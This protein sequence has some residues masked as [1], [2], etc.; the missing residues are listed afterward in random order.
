MEV[1]SLFLI[2]GTFVGFLAGLLGIGGGIIL[3]PVLSFIFPKIGLPITFVMQVSLGTSVACTFFSMLSS[4]IGHFKHG[5]INLNIYYKLLPGLII[6][7]ILGPFIA[8]SLDYN[9]LKN[10]FALLLFLISIKILFEDIIKRKINNKKVTNENNTKKKF[11]DNI[12]LLILLGIAIGTISALIGIGGGILLLSLF[13]F[14]E[15]KMKEAVGTAAIC[16]VTISFIAI[17][18]YI[19]SGLNT[20]PSNEL[21]MGYV[22][23]PAVVSISLTSVILAQISAYWSQKIPSKNLKRLLSCILIFTAGRMF[24]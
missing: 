24:W 5:K 11:H 6:G 17:I 14:M 1:I 4:S 20:I 19:I 8:H 18:G 12:W 21:Y 2:I 7:A 15:I 13:S 10:I 23:I 22:Y 16:G 3:V 9:S